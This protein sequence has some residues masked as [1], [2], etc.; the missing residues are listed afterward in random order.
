MAHAESVERRTVMLSKAGMLAI[1]LFCVCGVPGLAWA[2]GVTAN[3]SGTN[4]A[5]PAP[6]ITGPTA[7]A[8]RTTTALF[9]T[10]AACNGVRISASNTSLDG[11]RWKALA[12]TS[13]GIMKISL[14]NTRIQNNS[15]ASRTITITVTSGNNAGGQDFLPV[16]P[17]GRASG[18]ALSASFFGVP[19]P[20]GDAISVIGRVTTNTQRTI[21]QIPAGTTDLPRS[22]PSACAGN[23]TC[24][25]TAT[26][27]VRNIFDQITE[28]I[29][30]TCPT[31]AACTPVLTTTVTVTLKNGDRVDLPNSAGFSVPT[32]PEDSPAL[33]NDTPAFDAF[34]PFLQV[35]TLSK[36]AFEAIVELK[37]G[38]PGLKPLEEAVQLA[39]GPDFSTTIPAGGFKK[40]TSRLFVFAGKPEEFP[41]AASITQLASRKFLVTIGATGVNLAGLDDPLPV[42]LTIGDQ[43]GQALIK[44]RFFHFQ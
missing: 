25:F 27:G 40:K 29:Q 35:L 11:G 42:R 28:T 39:L 15:G 5:V 26:A 10:I 37:A 17:G 9:A 24:Q 7:T 20:L 3:V 34:R 44:P 2:L 31:S 23:N 33:L 21:N 36:F 1:A 30:V 6:A 43:T 32:T 41:V 18:V 14:N 19:N 12:R 8:P 13:G 16:T 4:C 38:G 22:L